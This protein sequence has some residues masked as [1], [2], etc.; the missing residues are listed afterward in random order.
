MLMRKL[1]CLLLSLVF[2]LV[3]A[4]PM[5][6]AGGDTPPPSGGGKIHPWDI[7]DDFRSDG[8]PLTVAR[9]Q[10]VIV[11]YGPGGMFMA[12]WTRSPGDLSKT[13]TAN[14]IRDDQEKRTPIR[15]A[16]AVRK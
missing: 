11:G 7:S 1:T 2:L 8:G 3:T 13:R 10:I 12:W 15:M 16:T 6:F 14:T 5:A 9:R 4:V